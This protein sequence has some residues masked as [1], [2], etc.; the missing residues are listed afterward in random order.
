MNAIPK[1]SALELCQQIRI[2]QVTRWYAW[3]FSPCWNCQV[4]ANGKLEKMRI[5]DQPGFTGCERVNARYRKL[6][7][8]RPIQTRT[9]AHS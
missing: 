4:Y 3:F 7:A 2:E 5:A 9:L 8:Q 1:H 6:S